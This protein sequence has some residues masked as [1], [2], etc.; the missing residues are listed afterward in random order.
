MKKNPDDQ[1]HCGSK[2]PYRNCHK[3]KDDRSRMFLFIGV[4]L[5]GIFLA[6]MVFGPEPRIPAAPPGKVW[7]EEH[8]HY[9]DAQQDNAHPPVGGP[10]GSAGTPAGA[11]GSSA[12]AGSSAGAPGSTAPPTP[13]QNI[14]E[15]PGGTP[16]GKVW[17]P[18]HGHYHD[19]QPSAG[20]SA[21]T[22]PGQSPIPAPGSSPVQTGVANT[23][24]PP[25]P[26]PAG[27]VWSTEHGHWHD[28]PKQ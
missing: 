13:G 11:T 6:K 17:S 21:I 10:A 4:V 23:P 16:A 14:P 25:R 15:P 5:G 1:C 9:H 20:Q 18:E 12:A 26:V 8:G 2:K 22:V 3:P 19:F 24:Q 28:A 27:K 7:S